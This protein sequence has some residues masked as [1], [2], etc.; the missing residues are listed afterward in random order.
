MNFGPTHTDDLNHLFDMPWL[1]VLPG[2][3]FFWGS[4]SCAFSQCSAF[5]NQGFVWNFSHRTFNSRCLQMVRACFNHWHFDLHRI[6][7]NAYTFTSI[8]TLK[9]KYHLLMFAN[10]LYQIQ[11]W[12]WV[13][14]P[15]HLIWRLLDQR[16]WK[17]W[18]TLWVRFSLL[19]S[20]SSW[21]KITGCPRSNVSKVNG[22][23]SET[24]HFWPLVGKAKMHL[25]TI[26]S[27]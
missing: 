6:T 10:S 7:A 13:H 19:D 15:L 12:R 16:H 4:W 26:Q 21:L 25:R 17:W 11:F 9:I 14:W 22:Y 23:I 24:K 3:G 20:S 18:Q 27:F 8:I 2:H 5:N 1:R